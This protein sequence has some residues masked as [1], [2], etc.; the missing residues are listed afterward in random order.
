LEVVLRLS[1]TKFLSLLLFLGDVIND[2]MIMMVLI[3]MLFDFD[4]LT[5]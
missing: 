1:I 5:L 3:A 2:L 4:R